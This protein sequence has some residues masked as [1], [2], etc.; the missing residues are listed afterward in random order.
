MSSYCLLQNGMDASSPLPRAA[1]STYAQEME[2]CFLSGSWDQPLYILAMLLEVRYCWLWFVKFALRR[3]K[4][5]CASLY[6][7]AEIEMISHTLQENSHLRWVTTKA[8]K[9]GIGRH[10]NESCFCCCINPYTSDW[11]NSWLALIISYEI[12]M[13]TGN[14]QHCNQLIQHVPQS[15]WRYVLQ[16]QTFHIDCY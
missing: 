2:Q 11:N 5:K 3:W 15:S 10:T 8:R 12:S 4:N 14:T 1:A 7:S 13:P 16:K 9:V 6:L